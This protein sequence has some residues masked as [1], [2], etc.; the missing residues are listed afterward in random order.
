MHTSYV[1]INVGGLLAAE[2]T[3]RTLVPRRLAALV[4]IVAEHGVPSSVAVVAIG[5]MV[6]ARVRV[7]L[8]V[9]LP[10]VLLPTRAI[11]VD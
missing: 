10:H 9:P 3:V 11:K 6:L 8:Y 5:T 2:M 7:E 4:S 1:L